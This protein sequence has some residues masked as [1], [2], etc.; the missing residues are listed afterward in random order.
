M[1]AA[2][3]ASGQTISEQMNAAQTASGRMVS[4]Q[5]A[6]AQTASGQTISE[7]M[8]AAQT[9]SGRMVSEQTAAAQTASGRMV[10]VQMTATQRTSENMSS[11]HSGESNRR[12]LHN[13]QDM[14]CNTL[15]PVSRD[16][17]LRMQT[18]QAFLFSEILSAHRTLHRVHPELLLEDDIAAALAVGLPVEKITGEPTNIKLTSLA[19]LS[20]ARLIRGADVPG[21]SEEF[22]V[23]Q[24]FDVHRLES[25]NSMRLCGVSIPAPFRLSGHS[26]ADAALHA[27]T[28][29]ILGAIGAGDIGTF[30]PPQDATWHNADSAIFLRHALEEAEKHQARIVN[31]DL[32]IICERPPL[33]PYRRIFRQRLSELLCVP[34]S[35]VSVKAK[36][37]ERLGALGREEGLAAH[38]VL[39]LA[40][41]I[42][43][44]RSVEGKE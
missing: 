31:A 11:N 17:L 22:R 19:D 20:L 7:Q 4:E 38:A 10:S 3:T 18:P 32:T 27:L 2:Q 1:T 16:R 44:Q 14:H 8:N 36:T 26:D 30:F 29:A 37:A 15:L 5:M 9:A 13:M 39:S 25:G 24:G 40:L 34:V 33:A 6:A 12:S 21:R 43:E 42:E 28:D 41:P 35:R 23:G